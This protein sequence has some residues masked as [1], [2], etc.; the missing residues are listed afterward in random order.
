MAGI[1][2]LVLGGLTKQ[3]DI[4]MPAV[5]FVRGLALGPKEALMTPSMQLDLARRAENKGGDKGALGYE[6]FGL[7]VAQPM[8]R[9][10]GGLF[11][12]DP[13]A[14][15]NVGSAGRVTY[16]KDPTQFGGYR[17]GDTEFNFTPDKDTGST[18][19][20]I[21]DFINEGGL[22]KKI[23]DSNLSK[24][25]SN[26]VFTPAGAAE[27]QNKNPFNNMISDTVLAEPRSQFQDYPGVE[28]LGGVQNFDLEG[29]RDIISQMEEEKGNYIE[30]PEDRF[31]MDGILQS[32][33]GYAKDAAG[34]Y[35]GSQALGGAGGMLFGPAGALVGGIAG[36]LGGGN[37]FNQTTKSGQF[38]NTLSGQGRNYV[39]SLYAPGGV[40]HGYY[41]GP[42]S[43]YGKSTIGQIGQSLSRLQ[44]QKNPS[45]FNIARQAALRKA[46]EDTIN[47]I[48]QSKQGIAAVTKAGS[49]GYDDAEF[50]G[51]K[52]S[53]G[54]GG[55]TKIVCTMMNES[56]GF[57][58]FRN[59]IWL[60]HSKDLPKEYEIGYHTIFLPLVNFAKK[61]GKLNKLVKK[62]LEHIAK[63][64]TID[65][66]QEM[67]GKKHL[68]GRIYRKVL[69]PICY[70]VGKIK[71]V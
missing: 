52:G 10:T 23:A 36:L 6:D 55:S 22:A 34:R 62:T 57:G 3:Y 28:N 26:L 25:L 20:K 65:L 11:S 37:L 49:Y 68:L 33:G 19:N 60:K 59:K 16:E 46:A 30:R 27:V 61:E 4:A 17:F 38:Y 13:T 70:L 39:N 54:T 58:N 69:E 21:L 53:G 45:N 31:N 5:N 50:S 40:L 18:G 44:A 63:H 64:R 1:L 51:G 2:D 66:K 56:Y 12:L 35:I 42:Q 8:G 15:A 32:L 14:F 67:R 41:T 9:F 71:N 24:T 43:G 48:D 7:E 29:V 47:N